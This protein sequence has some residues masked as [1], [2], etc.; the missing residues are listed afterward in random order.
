MSKCKV[1]DRFWCV[2]VVVS[3][4]NGNPGFNIG[5]VCVSCEHCLSSFLASLGGKVIY[6][7]RFHSLPSWSYT[8][9]AIKRACQNW[10]EFQ[11]VDE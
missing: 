8:E 1:L 5:N 3:M 10:I 11:V 2:Y 4:R 7:K 6:K 9:I